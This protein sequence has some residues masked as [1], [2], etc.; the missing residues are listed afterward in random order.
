[1]D[2]QLCHL[3][4]RAVLLIWGG[5]VKRTIVG[6]R[7]GRGLFVTSP[8]IALNTPLALHN[9][10]AGVSHTLRPRELCTSMIYQFKEAT[11]LDWCFSSCCRDGAF[12]VPQKSCLAS[13]QGGDCPKVFLCS[14]SQA[15]F[16]FCFNPESPL[17]FWQSSRIQGYFADGI[18]TGIY[19]K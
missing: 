7:S 10:G 3:P 17:A 11:C 6:C 1:M 8:C 12:A 13:W 9:F 19:R 15:V 18:L 5:G 16:A 14:C 4:F 2:C